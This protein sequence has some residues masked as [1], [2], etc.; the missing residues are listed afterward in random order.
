MGLCMILGSN[1]VSALAYD[2]STDSL[3]Q[4][5]EVEI[6]STIQTIE[7]KPNIFRY[8]KEVTIRKP[9]YSR[10]D[11]PSTY[12]Y[13]YYDDTTQKWMDGDLA[14]QSVEKSGKQFVATFSGKVGCWMN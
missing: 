4:G 7:I 6:E 10:N 13:R 3:M 5:M 1:S 9:Y 11:V 2:G 14:L 12:Y 8:E